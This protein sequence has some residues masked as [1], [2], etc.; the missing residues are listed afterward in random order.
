[1]PARNQA[2]SEAGLQRS[3]QPA[4]PLL[5]KPVQTETS[6]SSILICL[7]QSICQEHKQ[8]KGLVTGNLP[9]SAAS[10]YGVKESWSGLRGKV[11]HLVQ[12]RECFLKISISYVPCHL[13]GN[14]EADLGFLLGREASVPGIFKMFVRR[15]SLVAEDLGLPLGSA[16]GSHRQ[17][18]Y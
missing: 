14:E 13:E 10:V 8:C 11:F 5:R 3:W 12:R 9:K 2:D 4:G 18:P 6:L 16:N 7:L 17:H 1:M 15:S